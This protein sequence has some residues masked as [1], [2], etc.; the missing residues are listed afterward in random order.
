MFDRLLSCYTK[1]TVRGLLCPNESLPGVKCMLRPILAF[2][3]IGSVTARH[4]TNAKLCGV[5][6]RAPSVFGRAAITLGIGPHS[7]SFFFLSIF[8]FS[9]PNLSRRMIGCL[10][11]FHTRCGL[12]ANL[13]CRSETCCTQLSTNTGRK[14][15]AKNSPSGHHRSA[16]SGY[17]FTMKARIQNR[18]KLAKQ[19]YLLHTSS[20]YGELRPTNG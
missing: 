20:Q 3:Y 16:L 10:A 7:S 8:L 17:I 13:G 15:I 5:E 19:Q 1:Y 4:S 11:H 14:K 9:S 2:S 6:H 12:S 18:K